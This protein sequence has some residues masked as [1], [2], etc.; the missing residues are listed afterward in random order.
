MEFLK[1]SNSL[2]KGL[3]SVLKGNIGSTV[4]SVSLLYKCHWHEN[5]TTSE[6]GVLWGLMIKKHNER[7]N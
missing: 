3:G 1:C 7:V 2:P 6:Q 4:Q 5:I